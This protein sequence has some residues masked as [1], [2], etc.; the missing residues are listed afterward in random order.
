MRLFVRTSAILLGILFLATPIVACILAWGACMAGANG[1]LQLI[2]RNDRSGCYKRLTFG[3]WR[4]G[5]GDCSPST[6]APVPQGAA[7]TRHRIG[8]AYHVLTQMNYYEA[9]YRLP[10]GTTQIN[11]AQGPLPLFTYRRNTMIAV[12]V[13]GLLLAMGMFMVAKS[14]RPWGIAPDTAILADSVRRSDSV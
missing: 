14:V 6:Y 2:S 12:T 7:I 1:E 3:P 4:E 13:V 10:D 5:A 8:H 9:E 11:H